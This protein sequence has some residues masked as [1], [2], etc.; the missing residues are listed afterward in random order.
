MALKIS[1]A[2][3][4]VR[5]LSLLFAFLSTNSLLTAANSPSCGLLC[6]KLDG[7]A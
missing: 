6:I 7:L 3:L 1:L 4:F 5:I 2:F